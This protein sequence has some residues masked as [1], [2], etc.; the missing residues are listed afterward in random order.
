MPPDLEVF[1]GSAEWKKCQ[2]RI[3]ETLAGWYDNWRRQDVFWII[4]PI[5]FRTAPLY[6]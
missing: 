2:P 4:I 1:S 5:Y 3:V 6:L